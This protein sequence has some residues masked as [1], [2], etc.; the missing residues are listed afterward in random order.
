[1]AEDVDLAVGRGEL[2]VSGTAAWRRLPGAAAWRRCARLGSGHGNGSGAS[3]AV[4]VPASGTPVLSMPNGALVWGD[5][6][7]GR[8][9]VAR[10]RLDGERLQVRDLERSGGRVLAWTQP[11]GLVASDDAG[12]SWRRAG[13]GLP[14]ASTV[15]LVAAREGSVIVALLGE[16]ARLACSE[17][18]GTTF[19]VTDLRVDGAGAEPSGRVWAGAGEDVLFSDDGCASWRVAARPGGVA[20]V[21]GAGPGRVW[22]WTPHGVVAGDGASWRSAGALAT[23]GVVQDRGASAL[24][25]GE[26]GV[27]SVAGG[28]AVPDERGLRSLWGNVGASGDGSTLAMWRAEQVRI[29]TDGGRS[30]RARPLPA[31]LRVGLPRTRAVL[32]GGRLIASLDGGATFAS[33]DGGASWVEQHGGPLAG[34]VQVDPLVRGRGWW[35]PDLGGAVRWSDD[36]GASWRPL[37][38]VGRRVEVLPPVADRAGLVWIARRRNGRLLR[39][40]DD[41]RTWALLPRL[42]ASERAL[43]VDGAAG[44]LLVQTSESDLLVLRP[45]AGRWRS[46]LQGL[47]LLGRLEQRSFG[48]MPRTR[49][50]YMTAGGRVWSRRLDAARWTPVDGSPVG[51][52]ELARAGDDLLIQA[53]E[54]IAVLEGA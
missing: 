9:R 31:P 3:R 22:V 6:G 14:F 18:R 17:D 45:G 25:A 5:P 1:M 23:F 16:D 38:S 36:D 28:E 11:R 48:L 15:R 44:V 52:A 46:W 10:P 7:C 33:D 50:A 41:G 47:P 20:F 19:R 8:W 2:M 27:M 49:T 13:A 12:G 51:A 30:W 42:P 26:H 39:S 34:I 54:R 37:F 24:L 40:V 29:S 35:L 32:P 21:L 4:L 43:S 53:T